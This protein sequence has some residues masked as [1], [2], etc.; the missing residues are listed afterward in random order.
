MSNKSYIEIANY[1]GKLFTIKQIE[2]I[3]NEN[4]IEY[5]KMAGNFKC[6]ICMYGNV[7]SKKNKTTGLHFATTRDSHKKYCDFYDEPFSTKEQIKR[8]RE[9]TPEDSHKTI[10]RIKRNLFKTN[11]NKSKTLTNLEKK[12]N[13]ITKNKQNR[14]KRL[15]VKLS[16][17]SLK[18]P[19]QKIEKEIPKAYH[20]EE[21]INHVSLFG[22]FINFEINNSKN[23]QTIRIGCKL[24]E[25][26]DELEKWEK[27]K[28]KIKLIFIGEM[29]Y[30][31]EY[32]KFQ[33][34]IYDKE[35]INIWSDDE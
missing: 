24:T 30:N 4:E 34:S 18:R 3:K 15:E 2:K 11:E 28:T 6:P 19:L 32:D 5:F 20:G 9:M 8:F 35:K 29:Q 14:D 7:Y 27:N 1:D 12:D 13:D 10:E 17:F 25:M 33:I 22:N 26:K 16:Q 31:S 23:N 21:T